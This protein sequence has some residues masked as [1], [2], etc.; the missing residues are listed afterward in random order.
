[1]LNIIEYTITAIVCL[2]SAIVIQRI[3]VKEAK[4]GIE[5][6]SIQGIKWFGLAIFIWGI[7]AV[8]NF[9]IKELIEGG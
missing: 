2:I 5:M 8:G 3:F 9:V 4:K 1:M 6:Q 7:G